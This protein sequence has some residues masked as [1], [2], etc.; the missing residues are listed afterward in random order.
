MDIM[1]ISRLKTQ[2]FK[3]S[4]ENVIPTFSSEQNDF[5]KGFNPFGDLFSFSFCHQN[6]VGNPQ[7]AD[8]NVIDTFKT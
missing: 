1:N 4:R 3:H 6:I 5:T 2:T 8:R 7:V